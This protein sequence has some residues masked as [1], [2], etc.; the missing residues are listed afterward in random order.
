[1]M[2]RLWVAVLTVFCASVAAEQARQ[3]EIEKAWALLAKG[4]RDEA[5][6][7]L[8]QLIRTDPRN[9][10]ARL[11]L[12]SILME[13][14]QESESIQQLSKGVELRPKSADAHN[15]LGEAQKAF[16]HLE[17]ARR[18]FKR[19]V[20]LNPGFA[21]AHVNLAVAQLEA[22]EADTALE[23]LDR[24]IQIWGKKPDAAYP[25]YLRAKVYTERQEDAKAAA[26]LEQATALRPDFAEAWSDLGDA[27]KALGDDAGA[28]A[29]AQKAVQLSPD[30]AVAQTRLGSKLLDAGKPHEAVAPLQ[31]AVRADPKNQSA[32]N[33]L[34]MAL[35]R[36]GRA[37]EANAV[38]ERLA[39]VIR[40]RDKADQNQV[41]S[42]ELN[43]R[44][45]A[46]EKQG[47]V[48]GAAE[49]Y[50]AALALN[51]GHVGIRVNLAVALLKLGRWDEGIA[52]MRE[53]LRRDPGNQDIQKALDDA[54]SQAQSH[55]IVVQKPK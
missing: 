19:A 7:V 48:R 1:M 17:D 21:Q 26:D 33:A 20:E 52:E 25:R 45:A 39:E 22:G 49:K 35:R 27:R 36:D 8:K 11:M 43:N 23:H 42:V 38:R 6:A 53:A 40:E 54:I 50:R 18:E 9:A 12:G 30:D 47:D 32:L 4:Q 3:P 10:D 46:L 28:L 34:Q 14:G 16:G 29:A 13:A 51:P 41:A 24:A 55:G 2:A 15:A 5:A 37:E 31:Q 44:G